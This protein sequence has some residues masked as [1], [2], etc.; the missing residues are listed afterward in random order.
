M[1]PLT[2]KKGYPQG[3]ILVKIEKK[4][5]KYYPYGDFR[6]LDLRRY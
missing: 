1:S 5:L 2:N 4:I 6:K 3:F